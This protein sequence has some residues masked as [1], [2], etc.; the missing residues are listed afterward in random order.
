MH[1]ATLH[2]HAPA[3]GHYFAQQRRQPLCSLSA[4][5][6]P[7]AVSARPCSCARPDP[8]LAVERQDPQLALFA[9]ATARWGQHGQADRATMPRICANLSMSTAGSLPA[10]SADMRRAN[11]RSPGGR[12]CPVEDSIGNG[13]FRTQLKLNHFGSLPEIDPRIS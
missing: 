5:L 8:R 12:L 9:L 11:P 2:W 10:P 13:I 1:L 7:A 4:A 3:L 6:G